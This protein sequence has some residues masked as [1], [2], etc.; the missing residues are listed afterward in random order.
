MTGWMGYDRAMIVGPQKSRKTFWGEEEQRRKLTFRALHGN[1]RYK[2]CDDEAQQRC[3][4]TPGQGQKNDIQA[5]RQNTHEKDSGDVSY[6]NGAGK[7]Y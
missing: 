7:L 6:R 4:E 1:E 5:D 3:G 2:V